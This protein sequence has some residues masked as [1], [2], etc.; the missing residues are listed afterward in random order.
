MARGGA[1]RGDFAERV[2]FSEEKWLK[3]RLEMAGRAEP[4]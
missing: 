1:V 3:Q 4:R 2:R